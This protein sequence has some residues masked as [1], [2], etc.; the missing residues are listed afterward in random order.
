MGLRLEHSGDGLHR[1]ARSALDP[2]RYGYGRDVVGAPGDELVDHLLGERG[3]G[4]APGGDDDV[5]VTQLHLVPPFRVAH[6]RVDHLARRRHVR[7]GHSTSSE[8]LCSDIT[9]LSSAPVALLAV[10]ASGAYR[11]TSANSR[12]RGAPPQTG[13]WR[14]RLAI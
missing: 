11:T 5:I 7:R 1:A 9:V 3:A 10:A 2:G 6:E 14:R 8:A 4:L 12:F 13:H